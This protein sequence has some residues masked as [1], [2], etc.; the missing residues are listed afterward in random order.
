MLNEYASPL[1]TAT[2]AQRVELSVSQFNRQF[3]R[4]FHTTP[5]AYLK[6]VRLDVACHLLTTTELSMSEISLRTGF[7]DQSHFTNQFVKYRNMPPSKYRA[8]FAKRAQVGT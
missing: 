1:D 7:Y 5:R 8:G 4:R 3:R 6:N 2:L